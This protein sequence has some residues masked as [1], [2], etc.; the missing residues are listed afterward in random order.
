MNYIYI[1]LA[2]YLFKHTEK[3]GVIDDYINFRNFYSSVMT[4]FQVS[5]SD[6]WAGIN[7]EMTHQHSNFIYY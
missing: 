3:E 1:V 5:T 7:E 2:N 4:L 6:G